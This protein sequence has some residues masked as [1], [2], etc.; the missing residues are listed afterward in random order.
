[1]TAGAT[2]T[3]K[4]DHNEIVAR[5]DRLADT[6]ARIE[7]DSPDPA[8]ARDLARQLVGLAAILQLHFRKEEEVLLPVLDAS[9]GPDDAAAL[10]ARM[11]PRPS[12]P[13]GLRRVH[14]GGPPPMPP[15]AT[16][17]ASPRCWPDAYSM[18]SGSR[19]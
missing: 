4:A 3:M 8:L 14:P 1:M 19:S 18:S 13:S 10:F 2:A 12:R 17:P 6:L 15:R 7:Q 16:R 5:I 11:G 9:L